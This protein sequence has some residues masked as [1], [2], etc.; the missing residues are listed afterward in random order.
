MPSFETERM[1]LRAPEHSDAAAIARGLGE[2]AVARNM[3]TVAH[4]FTEA[5]A[6]AL[7]AAAGEQQAKG[8]AY[9]FAVAHKQTGELLGMVTLTLSAGFYTLSFWFAR[10]YWGFG[11]AT[12]AARKIAAFAFNTLKAET[13]RAS[14]FEGNGAS[15]R[16]LENLGFVAVEDY[17]RENRAEGRPM[18]CHCMVLRRAGFGRKRPGARRPQPELVEA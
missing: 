14:W 15:E 10:P 13:I 8:E 5:D 9:S 1:L 6:E 4:P 3:A 16:I 11:Y 18:W 12:E 7:I 2:F 17:R